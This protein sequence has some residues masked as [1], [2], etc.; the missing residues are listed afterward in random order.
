MICVPINIGCCCA[1]GTV[2]TGRAGDWHDLAE[3][4]VTKSCKSGPLLSVARSA[5]QKAALCSRVEI[6]TVA[7]MALLGAVLSVVD[8]PRDQLPLVCLD[9]IGL[10]RRQTP[11][12]S[13]SV[14]IRPTR[15]LFVTDHLICEFKLAAACHALQSLNTESKTPNPQ[16]AHC[17][18]EE[19]VLITS[20]TW[21]NT[22]DH[23]NCPSNS[24]DSGTRVLGIC[25]ERCRAQRS[26][27]RYV[28]QRP[29]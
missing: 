18:V 20:S 25:A 10:D 24:K 7:S 6:V 15:G 8:K 9:V 13:P 21:S 17:E 16:S 27:V 11:P 4:D 12:P 1:S 29:L 28:K 23:G 5:L 2:P 3:M 22:S 19:Q 14:T 26:R